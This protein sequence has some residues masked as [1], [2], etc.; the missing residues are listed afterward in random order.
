MLPHPLLGLSV[1]W[2][3][4]RQALPSAGSVSGVSFC[5]PGASGPSLPPSSSSSR[6]LSGEV[7]GAPAAA[8]AS[9]PRCA[10][11]TSCWKASPR[12]RRRPPSCKWDTERASL[13]C[14]QRRRGIPGSGEGKGRFVWQRWSSCP[15][16][17]LSAATWAGVRPLP[18]G[19]C[20][21]SCRARGVSFV[22]PV[23]SLLCL[24][25]LSTLQ[26]YLAV[27]QK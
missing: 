6:H 25:V 14:P 27:S 22:S 5:G 21:Y 3:G 19:C 8:S 1:A 11:C 18:Y 26:A 4:T 12:C 7:C 9:A 2:P 13:A 20:S 24:S 16:A 17:P 10:A 23:T 15:C